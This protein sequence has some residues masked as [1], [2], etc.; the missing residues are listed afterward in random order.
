MET[1]AE[2]DVVGAGS[3]ELEIQL[4]EKIREHVPS[5][6]RVLFSNSGSEATYHAIRVVAGRD[7]PARWS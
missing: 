2:L 7:R 1:A 3:S 4:A 6:E 5:A